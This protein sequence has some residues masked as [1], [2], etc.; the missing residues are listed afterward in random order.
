M[1]T[2]YP[3][4]SFSLIHPQAPPVQA[5][6][7]A[8]SFYLFSI[9]L[10]ILDTEW[11]GQDSLGCMKT[12]TGLVQILQKVLFHTASDPEIGWVG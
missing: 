11:G 8:L 9:I 1:A 7:H 4:S 2:R 6:D 10:A 5:D 12:S 3:S